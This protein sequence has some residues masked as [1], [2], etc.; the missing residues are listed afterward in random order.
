MVTFGSSPEGMA[1]A[2]GPLC[3]CRQHWAQSTQ[4][5]QVWRS[6]ACRR[7]L[8][9]LWRMLRKVPLQQPLLMRL[10]W[11]TAWLLW[12]LKGRPWN[13]SCSK[14]VAKSR[15]RLGRVQLHP[16]VPYLCWVYRDYISPDLHLHFA[17][18][19]ICLAEVALNLHRITC[20]FTLSISFQSCGRRRNAAG[21]WNRLASW[22]PKT[23][24]GS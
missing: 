6:R 5:T 11:M 23:W 16:R 19:N 15:H 21:C 3:G 22:A 17:L 14:P 9:L 18:I 20:L 1:F 4:K 7:Q 2:T 12:K 13:A 10:V 24:L 8:P